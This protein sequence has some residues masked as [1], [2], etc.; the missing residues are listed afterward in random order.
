LG[1]IKN[2]VSKFVPLTKYYSGNQIKTIGMGGACG[3]QG[4]NRT[5]YRCL[6]GNGR[7]REELEVRGINGKVILI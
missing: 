4:E 1:F 3:T 7:E 2:V 5:A 6:V